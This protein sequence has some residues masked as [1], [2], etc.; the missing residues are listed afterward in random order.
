MWLI[1][2]V[3]T[4][5]AK[6]Y[7]S[8]R[9]SETIVVIIEHS[10]TFSYHLRPHKEHHRLS[11][12]HSKGLILKQNPQN[13][14]KDCFNLSKKVLN[15]SIYLVIHICSMQKVLNL[16][17]YLVIHI[18]SMQKSAEFIYLSCDP[19]LFN[20]TKCSINLSIL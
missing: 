13:I 9:G 14:S 12:Q 18:C 4:D 20:A 17:I 8:A 5:L 19:H 6:I 7:G 16:S 11:V 1:S 2:Y 10:Q 3:Q 15:L